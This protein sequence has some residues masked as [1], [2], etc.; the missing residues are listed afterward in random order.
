MLI[1]LNYILDINCAPE[2]PNPAIQESPKTESRPSAYLVHIPATAEW[3][4]ITHDGKGPIEWGAT[5]TSSKEEDGNWPTSKVDVGGKTT[6]WT[7]R[8]HLPPNH[9]N[10]CIQPALLPPTDG[11]SKWKWSYKQ[12]RSQWRSILALVRRRPTHWT[13]T[14]NY[15]YFMMIYF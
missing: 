15:I 14:L 1:Y 2:E 7:R 11:I 5:S 12:N 6:Q 8:L 9:P 3:E 13:I 4:I 10:K